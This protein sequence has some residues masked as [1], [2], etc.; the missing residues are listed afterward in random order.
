MAYIT[1]YG[2]I[3][4]NGGDSKSSFASLAEGICQNKEIKHF[5]TCNFNNKYAYEVD[6]IEYFNI[7]RILIDSIKEAL[8]SAKVTNIN[9]VP[10]CIIIGTGL[11]NLKK[12]E[13]SIISKDNLDHDDLHFK[14]CIIKNLGFNGQIITISNACS[15][16][17][18]ALALADDMLN[19]KLVERAIVIGCDS[20]TESMFGLVDRVNPN[21]LTIV[22]PF[23]INRK[24]VLMGEGA[25]TVILENKPKS[26]IRLRG[27]SINC[28]AFHETQ[29]KLELIQDAM[30]SALLTCELSPND[31]DILFTHGTG[32]FQNDDVESNAISRIYTKNNIRPY[33]TGIKSMTGHTSGASGLM[34]LITAIFCLE[35]STVVSF[36][37]VKELISHCEGYNYVKETIFDVELNIAQINAFGFGGLNATA[38]I[39][40]I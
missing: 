21:A 8:N 17:L 35:N 34:S 13:E 16:S 2:M 26:R 1:G 6:F 18:Y 31:I 30:E 14:R 36:A 19:Q 9:E 38:I 24:G 11:R 33:I 39:E 37:N 5:K 29:P 23:D 20:I 25:A 4:A 40:K 3:S 7:E 32:T 28:D 22:Q 10:T 12:F 15:S 27:V